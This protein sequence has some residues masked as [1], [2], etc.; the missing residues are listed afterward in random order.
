MLHRLVSS[1]WILVLVS[2]WSATLGFADANN[3]EKILTSIL[4]VYPGESIQEAI[5]L[6]QPNDTIF[7]HAGTYYENIIVNK[8]VSVVGENSSTTIIYSPEV[9]GPGVSKVLVEVATNGVV[10]RG[11]TLKF[12]KE[13]WN[14]WAVLAI[15]VLNLTVGENIIE[16]C[17]RGIYF[18]GFSENNTIKG[19]TIINNSDTGIYLD[20]SG[21][22]GIY[23]NTLEKSGEYGI[24]IQGSQQRRNNTIY[25]NNLVKN[26]RHVFIADP[27]NVVFDVWDSGHPSGGN[28]WNDGSHV[29]AQGDGLA[30]TPRMIDANNT[31]RYPL[32]S[33]YWYWKNPIVGDLNRDMRVDIKDLAIPAKGYGS[34]PGDPN[35]NPFAD[36]NKDNRIDIKDLA[37]IA[38][39]YGK[40]YT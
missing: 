13:G 21:G 25:H 15:S 23:E 24:Q 8:T 38:K 33:P 22:N 18:S 9:G 19:N 36:L 35:W 34:Y 5:N 11:F 10:I 2:G 6:A 40:A 37:L 7:V 20:N 29:D 4:E 31:D 28:Y 39:N 12:P 17:T 1:L 32:M 26:K 14:N 16:D 27:N 3:T 30:D